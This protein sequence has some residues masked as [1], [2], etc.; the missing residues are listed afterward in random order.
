M[1]ASIRQGGRPSLGRWSLLIPAMLWLSMAQG[2]D[3]HAQSFAC[4][5]AKKVDEKT[6]CQ[7]AGLA[8]LD[9]V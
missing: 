8:N 4:D 1:N 9:V 3:S 5:A 2:T 6:I 7:N